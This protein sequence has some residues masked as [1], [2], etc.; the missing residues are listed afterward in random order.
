M[1]SKCPLAVVLSGCG[2]MESI[3]CE[4]RTVEETWSP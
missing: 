2:A 3:G 4:A 1:R